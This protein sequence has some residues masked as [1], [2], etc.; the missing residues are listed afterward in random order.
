MSME[1][2]MRLDHATQQLQGKSPRDLDAAVGLVNDL[3]EAEREYR[4]TERALRNEGLA[5]E[6]K[7]AA[8]SMGP[9]NHPQPRPTAEMSLR[10]A[11]ER[12]RLAEA[13]EAELEAL[14]R[15]THATV[16]K[17]AGKW[18][19][20]A[21]PSTALRDAKRHEEALRKQGRFAEAA[22]AK[23][24][25]VQLEGEAVCAAAIER[26]QRVEGELRRLK[27]THAEAAAKQRQ[28]HEGE[29]Y[30]SQ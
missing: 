5:L 13:Q 25:V 15:G 26:R 30:C 10:H 21:K 16:G 20:I 4:A 7:L 19:V 14:G 3:H 17:A 24:E 27:G 12:R 1:A 22:A 23:E 29:A 11:L 18:R 9:S 6:R 28:R 2:Q 8:L